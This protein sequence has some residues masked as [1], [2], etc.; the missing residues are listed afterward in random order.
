MQD[1]IPTWAA[2][3]SESS[4]T[5]AAGETL[6]SKIAAL[7]AMVGQQSGDFE[8]EGVADAP[9]VHRPAPPLDWVDHMEPSA[10]PEPDAAQPAPVEK[11]TDDAAAETSLQPRDPHSSQDDA[12]LAVIGEED[13]RRMVSEIVR[14]ELQGALGERITRNVRKLVRREIHRVILSQ[15]F[16]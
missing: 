9:F 4:K 5:Q 6:E 2:S 1:S 8:N 16:D 12:P 10:S 11:T 7:E 14:Q 13:L 3:Q 15:D